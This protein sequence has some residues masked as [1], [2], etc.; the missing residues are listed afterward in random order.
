M[1]HHTDEPSFLGKLETAFARNVVVIAL[2]ALCMAMCAFAAFAQTGPTANVSWTNP[3]TRTDGTTLS[4]TQIKATEIDY[5]LCPTGT[6]PATPAGTA[7]NTGSGTA[8]AIPLPS[9]GSWCFRARTVDTTDV[10]SVNSNVVSRQWLAPPN[11]PV[12]SSTITVAYEISFS[13]WGDVKLGR[14]VGTMPLGTPC[15]DNPILTNKGYYYEIDPALVKLTKRPKSA[16][17]VTR[18]EFA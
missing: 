6:F 8:M 18:C 13:R 3:T 11:P 12:L 2:V 16:I 9:Y 4:T 15:I 17:I 14:N 1:E 5:G 10:K 7:V